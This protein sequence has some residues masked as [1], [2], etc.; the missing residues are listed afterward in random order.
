MRIWE[1]RQPVSF[2]Y[3]RVDGHFLT[4][5]EILKQANEGPWPLEGV[6]RGLL[7]IFDDHQSN[8]VAVSIRDPLKFRVIHIPHDGESRLLYR[9]LDGFYQGIL[10][11][12]NKRECAD[13]FFHEA[14][15]DYSD[16]TPRTHEDSLA[17]KY[18]LTTDGICNEY[19][20]AIQLLGSSDLSEWGALLENGEMRRVALERLRQFSDSTVRQLLHQDQVEFDQFCQEFRESL[21]SVGIHVDQIQDGTLKIGKR[22]FLLDGFYCR[23]RIPDALLRAVRW[24]EDSLAGRNPYQR[25]GHLKSD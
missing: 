8:L 9:D 1:C 24:I 20:H 17:G 12:H 21:T 16:D 7:P 4:T 3:F 2:S 25:P 14:D 22:S 11:A 18:L 13:H 23:R 15:G 10:D 19:Y 6:E 5:G